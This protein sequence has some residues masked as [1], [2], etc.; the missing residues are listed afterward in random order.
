MATHRSLV[1]PSADRSRAD[2]RASTA[3]R[4]TLV[5]DTRGAG[6]VEYVILVGL[7]ALAALAGFSYFGSS[8]N[9]KARSLG[10]RVQNEIP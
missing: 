9:T 8:V 5:S 3:R 1:R 4:P 6:L 10:D 2:T 7:I